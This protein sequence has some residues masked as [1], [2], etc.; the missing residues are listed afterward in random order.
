MTRRIQACRPARRALA[1]GVSL[2]ETLCAT[3]IVATTL[4]LAAPNF[5]DWQ[6]RQ[7]L[8]A[9]AA[10]LETDIQY[11]R[12]LAVARNA[13][14]R[15]SARPLDQGGSCYAIHTGDAHD[16]VCG[17]NGQ[18]QCEGAAEVLRVVEHPAG[19]PAR[20]LNPKLSIAFAGDHGTVTPTA[21]FKLADPAGRTLHQVVNVMGRTRT[22]SPQGQVSGVRPC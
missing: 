9:A 20:L 22:C 14:V 13:A 4:G 21:T 18:V 3:S 7:A 6:H 1:R 19:G 5:S 17:A 15:L 12:S 8:L 11:A 16:C 2:V 10:E